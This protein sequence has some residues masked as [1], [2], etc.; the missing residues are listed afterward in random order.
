MLIGYARVSKT[1]G[2]QSLDLQK[3]ALLALGIDEHNIYS[4]YASG[5]LDDRLNLLSCLV[6]CNHLLT[7][8]CNQN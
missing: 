8:Y 2:S 4:D 5:K 6:N 7:L 3:D 1:D